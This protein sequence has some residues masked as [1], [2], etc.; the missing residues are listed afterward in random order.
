MNVCK[1]ILLVDGRPST[2]ILLDRSYDECKQY[3][4]NIQEKIMNHLKL[5]NCEL[6]IIS[7]ETGRLVS[8]IF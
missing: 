2:I 4:K 7:S 3:I 6:V 8:D 1:V 5:N